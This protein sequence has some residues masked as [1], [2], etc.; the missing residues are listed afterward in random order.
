MLNRPSLSKTNQITKQPNNP[1][2]DK[3]SSKAKITQNTILKENPPESLRSS[4]KAQRAIAL[5]A[6]VSAE[7]S[8]GALGWKERNH[9]SFESSPIYTHALLLVHQY[10]NEARQ[11]SST[12]Q[13]ES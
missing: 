12:E 7:F 13:H 6:Q 9:C 5:A 11:L 3:Q 2:P 8:N 4:E 1:K 10:A